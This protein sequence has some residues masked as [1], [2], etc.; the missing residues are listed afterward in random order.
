LPELLEDGPSGAQRTIVLA[1][2]AGSPMDSPFMNAIATGLA[3][4][5]LRV[6][7]F[8]FP[9]MRARREAGRRGPP[10]PPDALRR[11]WLDTI[12]RLGPAQGLVLG[13]KSLG[14]RIA[15]LIADEVGAAGLVCLG[16]P[17]HPPE[18]PAKLRTAHLAGLRTPALILQGTRDPLGTR[19][20]IANYTLS[21]SIRLVFLEDG[22][23]SFK[24]RAASGHTVEEHLDRAIDEVTR[25]VA[26]LG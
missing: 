15:S 6:V 23:H 26:G 9:Y 10:D 21:R 1:H 4:H 11:S 2:G 13:G 16:Y 12:E 20:E 7:R 5:G 17:F 8:E 18:Q 14:G 25:F 24:P 22:D 3:E 19:D